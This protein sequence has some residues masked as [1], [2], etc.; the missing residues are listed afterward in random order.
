VLALLR[1]F[2]GLGINHPEDLLDIASHLAVAIFTVPVFTQCPKQEPGAGQ[3]DSNEAH[4]FDED[5]EIGKLLAA[6]FG[7]NHNE[8][9]NCGDERDQY[10]EGEA[11]FASPSSIFP[12]DT[13]SHHFAVAAR[14]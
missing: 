13:G 2:L 10:R 3:N 8:E 11:R 7:V 14:V 1:A 12:E 6:Q 9:K 4:G 5:Y